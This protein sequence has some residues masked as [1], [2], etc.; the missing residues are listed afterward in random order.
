MGVSCFLVV[1]VYRHEGDLEWRTWE[2]HPVNYQISLG[3]HTE[4]KINEDNEK[5][6]PGE[7]YADTRDGTASV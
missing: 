4:G 6:R 3:R 7:N 2:K 1:R 5:H